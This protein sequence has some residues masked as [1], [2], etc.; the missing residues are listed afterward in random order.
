[1][2]KNILM[3]INGFG[4]EQR[5]SYNVYSES[6]MPNMDKLTKTCLF[7]SLN[8]GDLDYKTGYRRFSIG[9]GEELTYS[10]VNNSINDETYKNN[11]LFNYIIGQLNTNSSKLH[12]ICYWDNENT[13]FQLVVF[14]KEVVTRTKIPVDVHLVLNQKS[15]N[16]YRY[17]EKSLNTLNYEL[18][19]NLKVGIVSGSNNQLF[20]KDF[21]KLFVA[22]SGE[23]W[24]DVSKKVEVLYETKTKPE[25]VRTFALNSG[26]TLNDNDSILFFNYSNIDVTPFT[27]ELIEQ[28]YRKLNLG[29]IRFYSLFPI[30]CDNVNIPSM[31][32]YAVSSTYMLNS[33]KTINARC[34]IM[35]KQ[36]YCP[37][38]NNYLTGLRNTY[39]ESIKY[40]PTDNGFIYDGNILLNTI[41][42]LKEEL[43]IVN[44]EIDD[45]KTVEEIKDRLSKIDNVIG[46]LYGYTSQNNI[47]L[48]ISSLYG[49]E[50]ELYNNKHEL[51]KINFSVRAPV[52]VADPS[53]TK[54]N[55][56]LEE[57]TVFNLANSVY[58]NINGNYRHEGIVKRKKGILSIFKK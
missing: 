43:V 48:F 37:E 11:E 16:D 17:I 15:L 4:V 53:I 19:N 27:K 56:T 5:D 23:K 36:E 41:V 57:G 38:I 2:K 52:I 13:F 29:T 3:F 46:I 1:M 22:D 20:Y 7:G 24:K 6:L 47:G 30:K 44:Y 35:A 32:N 51:C 54:N 9:I 49:L 8:S 40:M 21:M 42:S 39:E 31:Y 14:L 45:C 26:T 58:K 10:I 34:M 25:D 18:G 55:Y 12:V 50:K 28:K 33:I